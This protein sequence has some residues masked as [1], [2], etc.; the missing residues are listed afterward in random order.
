MTQKQPPT[1]PNPTPE[2]LLE[3]RWFHYLMAFLIALG[4]MFHVTA[5]SATKARKSMKSKD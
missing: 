4:L 1:P 3:K 5:N 2:S